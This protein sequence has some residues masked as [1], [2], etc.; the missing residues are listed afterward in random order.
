VSISFSGPQPIGESWDVGLPDT[1][2]LQKMVRKDT[3]EKMHE[4][5][6][7][8]LKRKVYAWE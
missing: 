2:I 8:R 6:G 1:H 7:K 3:D 4:C 5:L